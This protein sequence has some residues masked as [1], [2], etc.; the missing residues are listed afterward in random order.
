MSHSGSCAFHGHVHPSTTRTPLD[1]T[2]T[3]RQHVHPL[4]TRTPLDNT[5]TPRQQREDCTDMF[6]MATVCRW[7]FYHKWILWTN[8]RTGLS[9]NLRTSVNFKCLTTV[10]M[11]HTDIISSPRTEY[12]C[13]I[14]DSRKW[15]GQ[16]LCVCR[17]NKNWRIST[18]TVNVT[19]LPTYWHQIWIYRMFLL[20]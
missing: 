18:L 9:Q 19:V 14:E 15:V 17:S 10:I 7:F 5:Y 20:T 1:N 6:C 8:V 11:S 16:D 13:V 2:S 4:T 12:V 3:P